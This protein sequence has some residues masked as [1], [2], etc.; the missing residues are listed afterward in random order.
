MID[1]KPDIANPF[2]VQ[3][4]AGSEYFCDR[5]DETQTIVSALENGRNITLIAPRRIGKTGLIHN[6]FHEIRSKNHEALCIYLDI[7]PTRCLQDFISELG[8]GVFDEIYSQGEKMLQKIG[9]LLGNCRP[10]ISMDTLTGMPTV[11]FDIAPSTEKQTLSDIF[12]NI[13]KSGKRCYI[14]IDEFQQI[15]LYPETGTEAMLRSQ[16]QFM[17]NVNFIFAGSS[18]H[19]MAEMF[20]SAKRP[21]YNSTQ[22]LSL[23]PIDRDTYFTF[24]E[25][26]FTFKGSRL[27][28]EVFYYLYDLFEGHTW[29][30]QTILNRL[31]SMDTEADKQVVASTISQAVDENTPVYQTLISLLPN[32]QL[33][34]LRAIAKNGI[35][36][37]P[38]NGTFISQYNLKA[39]STVNSA[40]KVLMAKELIY[41]GEKG[42]RVYDRFLSIWLSR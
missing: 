19:M 27:N 22:I 8:R 1:K 25:Q 15:T 5:K 12:T 14:A 7:F 42:Y 10:V 40:M 31:Y 23:Q 11:T 20:L 39:A 9:S 17:P 26:F 13:V 16:I 41:K 30:I 36:T 35:V 24:A 32:Q 3:G 18:R 28:K 38:T 21:F 33:N 37:A 34:L 29:Y 4:Y 2:V 6:V